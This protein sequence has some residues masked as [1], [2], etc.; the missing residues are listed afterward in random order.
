ML[1]GRWEAELSRDQYAYPFAEIA[2]MLRSA[3]ITL[4]NLE[5]PLTKGGTEFKDKKFRFRASPVAAKALKSAGI[6]T[7]TLA[8]NHSMD[9]GTQGLRDTIS[10][11]SQVGIRHVGAGMTLAEAR[12]AV[13]YEIRGTRVAILGYSLTL[14]QEFWGTQH[15]AGTAPLLE[16]LVQADIAAAQK[17]A[18]III[19]TVHWGEEGTTRL[20]PYQTRLAHMIIDAGADAV[21]G[22][23]PHVLQGIEVYKKGIIFYSLGNFVFGSKGRANQN[24]LLARLSFSRNQYE[25][26]LVPLL[27]SSPQHNFQPHILYGKPA[28]ALLNTVMQLP[29]NSP[30][31]PL[32]NRI[33]FKKSV[34]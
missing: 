18:E 11:L 8:N 31:K 30:L 32:K 14:P 26:E 23:H 7:V 5:A 4:V 12:K 22:H 6:T 21:I 20:R 25:A 15:Q 13:I 1:G 34:P 9:F 3:D 33:I 2:P 19:V 10:A 17:Q 28:D 29:P 24:S 27:L 16:K